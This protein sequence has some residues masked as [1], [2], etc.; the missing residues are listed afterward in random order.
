V[1]R[2]GCARIVADLYRR[3]MPK[4]YAAAQRNLSHIFPAASPPTI[5]QVARSLFRH[6]AYY[7]SDLFSLNRQPLEV[8][9]R[10]LHSIH[11]LDRIQPFLE[12]SRGFVVATAHLGNWELGGRLLGSYGKTIYVVRAPDRDAAV[13]KLL[14]EGDP[15]SSLHFV[16]NDDT[17][18]FVQLLMA[19]R[20]GDVVA[21][22]IDRGTG[23]RSDVA[24]NFFG[25]P[26][27]LPSGPFILARA[28][29]VPV[30]PCFCLM[31]PDRRYEIH[32]GEAIVAE[33]GGEEAA[34]QQMTRVLEHHISLVPDQWYSFYDVWDNTNTAR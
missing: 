18:G 20:R 9:Q 28:A 27:S 29:Q 8:Q 21:V 23:H 30:F 22:Q 25:A 1:F 12:S 2:F 24:V 33:R 13:H 11:N 3:R 10:Y 15:S 19:L 26:V 17:G 14:R 34:L 31:R 16:S 6:F 5:A 4:E 7:F 32:L